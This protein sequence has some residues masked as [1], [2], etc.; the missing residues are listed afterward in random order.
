MS[1]R[2]LNSLYLKSQY[3]ILFSLY[4]YFLEASTL[5]SGTIPH[6]PLQTNVTFGALVEREMANEV[7]QTRHRALEEQLQHV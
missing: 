1:L 3:Y 7:V 5:P 4:I 2:I 6:T